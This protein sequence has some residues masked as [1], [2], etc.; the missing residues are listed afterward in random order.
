MVAYL[1]VALGGA[2]GS[3]TRFWLNGLISAGFGE[4]FPIGTLIINVTGSF[5]IGFFSTLTGT[6]GRW[7][8]PITARQFV[9]VGICGGYTT[10]SSFS[11]QTLTLAQDGQWFRAGVNIVGSV[12][13]CL[14][15]VWLGHVLAAHLNSMKGS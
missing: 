2:L 15:A 7:L 1:W 4:T 12:V 14:V 5:A 10:F 3:V 13:F 9:M 6:D 11:L 8:V